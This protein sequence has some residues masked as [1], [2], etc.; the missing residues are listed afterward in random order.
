[1]KQNN[2]S[3]RLH[4]Q[5]VVKKAYKVLITLIKPYNSLVR[6]ILEYASVI[7][8]PKVENNSEFL[9]SIKNF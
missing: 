7:W 6:P 5:E 9:E 2:L 3:L 4:Y 1:M 8:S